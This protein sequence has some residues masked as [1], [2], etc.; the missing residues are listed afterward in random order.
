MKASITK[1]KQPCENNEFVEFA[2]LEMPGSLL[3]LTLISKKKAVEDTDL[4]AMN[5]HSVQ[6]SLWE[7]TR[8]YNRGSVGI[9]NGSH[10]NSFPY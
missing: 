7:K 4:D 8:F 9:R 5:C 6:S 10:F 2:I 3:F 1:A